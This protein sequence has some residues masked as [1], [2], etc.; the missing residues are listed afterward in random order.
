MKVLVPSYKRAGTASTMD[1][2]SCA[3]IVVPESQQ[4]EYEK[5]YPDR[6]IAIDDKKDGSVAKKRNAVLDLV[7]PG[8]LLWMLDDDLICVDRIKSGQEFDI[9]QILENHANMMEDHN[10]DFGGFSIYSD[11]VKYAEYAPFSLTK[12][13]YGAV[14]IRNI[15]VRYDEDLGRY[16][17]ADYFLKCLHAKSK[18]LRDNRYFFKFECNKDVQKNSKKNV[19]IGGIAGD[20]TQ[21]NNALE[22]LVKR[23]GSVIKIK[24]GK[25]NGV[26][27]PIKGV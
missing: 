10:A 12:P 22:K 16:E 7:R 26:K 24:D 2:I 25:M 13:S 20:E 14:C 23:W 9:E 8:E 27:V 3:T 15:G 17:D 4:A 11:P 1:L 18:V 6:V 21:Y 5:A 19:Q